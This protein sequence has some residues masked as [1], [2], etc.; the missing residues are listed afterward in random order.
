M[1]SDALAYIGALIR[2]ARTARRWTQESLGSRV[3]V[4]ARTVRSAEQGAPTVAAGTLFELAVICGLNITG[5][6]GESV[7]S[8]HE[9]T[10]QRLRLLPER[11]RATQTINDD[12]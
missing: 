12:F 5:P 6:T 9:Q 1:T 2:E 10:T 4:T 7:A 11:V 3:G 8:L